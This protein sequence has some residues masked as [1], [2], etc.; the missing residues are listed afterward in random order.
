M[1]PPLNDRAYKVISEFLDA[2][3]SMDKRTLESKFGVAEPILDEICESLNDYFGRKPSIGLAPIE[4]AFSGKR[5]SRPY[6][7]LFEM[8][9]GQSW[10]A[11]CVLWMDGRAEEPILH[12]ELCKTRDELNLKFKYIGS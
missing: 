12:V 3:N 9:G 5:G 6:I 2:I 7:D 4:L 11:E 10:G 8:D 1:N